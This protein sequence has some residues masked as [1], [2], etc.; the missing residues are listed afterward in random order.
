MSVPDD[1]LAQLRLAAQAA[2]DKLGRN[3]VA[4]DV[5]EQLTITDAFLVVSASNERQVG[6]IVDGIEERLI[7]AGRKPTRREGDRQLRWV[8]LDYVDFVVH[9]QHDEERTLYNLERL[10]KD[11]QQVELGLVAQTEQ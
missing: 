6:A 1:V 11:C 10:W 5:S 8:L 7:Q 4:F 9:V 2:A 3:I